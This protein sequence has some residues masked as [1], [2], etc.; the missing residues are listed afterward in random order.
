M[1]TSRERQKNRKT[2]KQKNEAQRNGKECRQKQSETEQAAWVVVV[3]MQYK[4]SRSKQNI[5]EQGKKVNAE[6]ES[7]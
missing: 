6:D 1:T 5:T 4:Q 3:R 2:E 7:K